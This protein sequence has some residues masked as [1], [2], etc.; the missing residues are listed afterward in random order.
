ME[1]D[2]MKALNGFKTDIA[3]NACERLMERVQA[4]TEWR[5]K[6]VLGSVL[7]DFQIYN[8]IDGK[9]YFSANVNN[10]HMTFWFRQYATSSGRWGYWKLEKAFDDSKYQLRKKDKEW[11]TRLYTIE[12]VDAL[13]D[14]LK[15]HRAEPD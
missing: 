6:W 4:S 10:E 13:A 7:T 15:F 11:I 3:R 9:W 14:I 12:D 2:A 5:G 1:K 8:Q